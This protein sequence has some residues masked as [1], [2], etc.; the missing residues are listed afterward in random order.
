MDKQEVIKNV[1]KFII[2]HKKYE[3]YKKRYG[4]TEEQT[5]C[6]VKEF[7]ETSIIKFTKEGRIKAYSAYSIVK[8]KRI[9]N[10]L[11]IAEG[12]NAS[13]KDIREEMR[14][15][16]IDGFVNRKATKVILCHL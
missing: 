7:F 12:T 4:L 15:H 6:F 14:I 5:Y 3:K 10:C 2:N 16:K 13:I 11:F 8:G 1:S 9:C